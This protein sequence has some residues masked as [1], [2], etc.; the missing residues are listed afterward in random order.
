VITFDLMRNTI[1]KLLFV[2]VGLGFFGCEQSDEPRKKE[3]WL[4]QAGFTPTSGLVTFT[5]MGN[6]RIKIDI[7]LKPFLAGNYPAHLHYGDINELGELA[8]RL[9]DVDGETGKSVTILDRARLSNGDLLTYEALV[10][11]NGSIKIHSSSELFKHVVVAFGN[12]G[13]NDEYAASGLATC[14]GH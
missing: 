8:I 14:V 5:D 13:A 4:F 7:K 3:Y 12:V 6:D 10:A 1:F 2:L 11:M 9:E